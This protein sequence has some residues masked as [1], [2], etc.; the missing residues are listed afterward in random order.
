[1]RK[2][3][4]ASVA[5]L[6]TAGGLMGAALAQTPPGA[7]VPQPPMSAPVPI[8]GPIGAPSQGQQAWPAAPA[9]V[10][11]VNSNN[12]YQAPMLPG[13]LANPTP[14]TIV[15]HIN[16][17]VQVDVGG[18]WTSAD[19]RAFTAPNG[20]PGAAPI[21]SIGSGPL[22]A[23]TATSA[24]AAQTAILG[25]NG[26]GTAKLQP[27]VMGAFARLYFGGDGMA[28]NG[29][30]YGAAIE[31]RENFPGEQ[32]G[33]SAST[34]ASL[35]TIYIRRAFTY[36]AGDNWGIVRLGQADGPI[37]IFDNGVTTFQFLPTGDFNGGDTQSFMPGN[38]PPTWIWLSQAEPLDVAEIAISTWE[39]RP[40]IIA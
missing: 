27:Q 6:G 2:F 29:L 12:N 1:M 30:R 33:S 36:V 25:V 34:Y 19:Q 38:V 14:G 10:A 8:S 40:T 11:Y 9:P 28:T 4:L 22:A 26:T 17:K 23:G 32:S 5:T 31:V 18:M 35:E 20:A 24:S 13:A 21:T 7:P 16:A 37:G 15:V 39:T 3:L